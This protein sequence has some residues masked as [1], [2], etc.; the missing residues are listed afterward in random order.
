MI[1]SLTT[2]LVQ[3]RE[4]ICIPRGTITHL[5]PHTPHTH[6]LTVSGYEALCPVGGLANGVVEQNLLR[7]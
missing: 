1:Y 5:T 4:P 7:E 6:T 2:N 3:S